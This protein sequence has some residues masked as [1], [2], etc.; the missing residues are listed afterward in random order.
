MKKEVVW[1]IAWGI[2][3]NMMRK[4]THS[5]FWMQW[6]HGNFQNRVGSLK[7]FQ[8]ILAWCSFTYKQFKPPVL[9]LTSKTTFNQKDFWLDY[10]LL[11]VSL[12]W[13][14][15]CKS[16]ILSPIVLFFWFSL[17]PEIHSYFRV[18]FCFTNGRVK[19]AI[20]WLLEAGASL[21]ARKLGERLQRWFVGPSLY[22]C[23]MNMLFVM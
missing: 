18:V 19:E 14:S 8:G 11:G 4:F 9:S 7:D 16:R 10:I 20:Q 12:S 17:C 5:I 1:L 2:W 6:Q 15:R 13:K 21:E 22:R 3:G 23:K